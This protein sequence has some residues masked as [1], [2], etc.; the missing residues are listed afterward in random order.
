MINGNPTG[1]FNS[2]RGLRQGDPMSSYLFVT[3]M[4]VFSILVDKA[5]SGDSL[6]SFNLVNIDGEEMQITHLLLADDNP[7]VLY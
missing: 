6:S 2:S 7:S 3:S 4:E 5:T 1:F